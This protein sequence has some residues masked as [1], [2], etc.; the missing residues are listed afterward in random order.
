MFLVSFA[1]SSSPSSSLPFPPLPPLPPWL[2]CVSLNPPLRRRPTLSPCVNKFH[3]EPEKGPNFN[4]ICSRCFYYGRLHC[5]ATDPRLY[6]PQQ[7]HQPPRKT[8]NDAERGDADSLMVV[9]QLLLPLW[10]S[11]SLLFSM[12]KDD[13]RGCASSKCIDTGR[14][15][16]DS[17]ELAAAAAAATSVAPTSASATTVA[18]E[19][20]TR[21]FIRRSPF[22]Y[23][24]AICM[25][26]AN[27]F[28]HLYLDYQI[29]SS[30]C[31]I[32][33]HHSSSFLYLFTLQSFSF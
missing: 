21:T 10:S 4:K 32:F 30:F 3:T 22:N 24:A 17:K 15:W 31:S 18:Y 6:Q 27:S 23:V 5:D 7:H 13:A 1:R 16:P 9:S 26:D 12:T 2:P 8:M 11:S 19:L 14:S 29:S 28:F 20:I 33:Y 25:F